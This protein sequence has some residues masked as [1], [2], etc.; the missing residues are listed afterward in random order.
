MPEPI[1]GS[2][3]FICIKSQKKTLELLVPALFFCI[4]ESEL[5]E[6]R[7]RFALIRFERI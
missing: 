5:K 7:F 6:I 1:N 2:G 4:I 3:I